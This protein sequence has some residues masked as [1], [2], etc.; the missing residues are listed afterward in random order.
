MEENR[1]YQPSNGTEGCWFIG[2]FCDGCANEKYSHTQAE[3]DKQCDILSATL[4]HDVNDEEYPKEW[5]YKDGEPTCTAF[6]PHNWYDANGDL[7]EP[8]EPETVDPDQLDLFPTNNT[9]NGQ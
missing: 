4:I 8:E 9:E 5:I 2:K 6:V 3:G 7:V 1:K